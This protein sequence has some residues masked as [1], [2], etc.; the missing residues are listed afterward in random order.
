M[1]C[2]PGA[3]ILKGAS[4]PVLA[5]ATPSH[6]IDPLWI[7]DAHQRLP[8]RRRPAKIMHAMS[9]GADPAYALISIPRARRGHENRRQPVR[10]R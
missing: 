1:G 2:G 5:R 7:V 9:V 3:C 4:A 8:I 10:Q 6:T